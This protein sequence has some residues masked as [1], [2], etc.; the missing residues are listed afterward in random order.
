MRIASLPRTTPRRLVAKPGTSLTRIVVLPIASPAALANATVS[1]EHESCAT[2]SRSFIIGTGLKKCIPITL[3]GLPEAAAISVIDRDEVLVPRIQSSV[4][5]APRSAKISC[6]SEGISGTASITISTSATACA[7][8]S[9]GVNRVDQVAFC[10]GVVLP[11]A[12]PLSQNASILAMP[13]AN[14]S[15]NA[16]KR[17][18]FQ[19]A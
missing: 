14:P 1:F 5:M 2:S 4:V 8:S 17:L 15:G 19:P 7:M 9:Y 10:S 18:V 6:L 16:S 3:S 11:R 13:R 12:I